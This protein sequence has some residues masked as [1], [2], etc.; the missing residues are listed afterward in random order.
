M[1]SIPTRFAFEACRSRQKPLSALAVQ[2]RPSQRREPIRE[3][4]TSVIE[5]SF[6]A[7]AARRLAWQAKLPHLELRRYAN[8]SPRAPASPGRSKRTLTTLDDC[9]HAKPGTAR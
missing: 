9:E 7:V 6:P 1:H 5:T 3:R 2:T 8:P 4:R